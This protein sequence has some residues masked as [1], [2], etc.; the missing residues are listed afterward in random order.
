MLEPCEAWP[1]RLTCTLD[2]ESPTVTGQAVEVATEILW[3]LSGRQFGYCTVTLR[4]CRQD[5]LVAPWPDRW[6]DWW[7]GSTWPSPALIGG[8]WFN[9]TCG[10]CGDTCSCT[11]ISQVLLPGYVES[12]ATVTVKVDGSPL[13]TGAY[14][15]DDNRYLVRTDGSTW[16]RCNDLTKDDTKTGTWSVTAKYGHAVPLAGQLAAGE[17]TCEITRALEGED[18]RLPRNVV[19]LVR[20]GVTISYPNVA[21]LYDKQRTGL[22]MVDLFLTAY[23]P[24]RLARRAKTYSVDRP[25]ARRVGT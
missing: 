25:M 4:P 9:L 7:P 16:P 1:V 20:Q 24:N 12:G 8:Q 5:C 23:N 11:S 3:A 22:Q 17:L 13:V 18:C 14:R 19:A 10:T 2:C 15:V 6:A 21:E